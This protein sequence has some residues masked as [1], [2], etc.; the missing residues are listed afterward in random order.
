MKD[1]LTSYSSIIKHLAVSARGSK[2]RPCE[3]CLTSIWHEPLLNCVCKYHALPC[4]ADHFN[5]LEC[6]HKK[7]QPIVG[8]FTTLAN[9]NHNVF[10]RSLSDWSVTSCDSLPSNFKSDIRGWS[11]YLAIAFFKD[12]WDNTAYCTYLML[13]IVVFE[14]KQRVVSENGWHFGSNYCYKCCYIPWRITG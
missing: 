7:T 8:T 1:H 9:N 5:I 3:I 13:Q 14:N 4:I 2:L 6:Y 10:G 12:T 11:R